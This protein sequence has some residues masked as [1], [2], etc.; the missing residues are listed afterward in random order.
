METK[1]NSILVVDDHQLFR[2]GLSQM[3]NREADLHVCAEAGDDKTAL[4]AMQSA[5][6]DMAII[7]ISLAGSNGIDLIK[8]IRTS[9]TETPILVLSMHDESLYAERA[10]RS[11]ANG[12]IMKQEANKRV[13]DAI[14]QVLSGEIYLSE[15]MSTQLVSKLI[16]GRNEATKSPMDTLSPRELE[17]FELIGQGH[18]TRQIAEAMKLTIP[19]INS[20]RA[21]IK[22]KLNLKNASEL[23]LNAIQWVQNKQK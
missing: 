6:P 1:K 13:R 17:V 19:T 15:K 18:G 8:L 2:E 22:E 12:Y 14:R 20:F 11:G 21:R 23:V 9:D 5:K 16:G 7:D 10:L 4:E 3:I